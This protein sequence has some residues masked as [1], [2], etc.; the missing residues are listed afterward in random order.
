[1][2]P[3]PT[4]TAD[5]PSGSTFPVGDTLVTV[6]ATDG[7]GNT[8]THSFTVTVVLP[9]DTTSPVITSPEDITVEAISLA[10]AVVLFEISATDDVDPEPTVTADP[11]SGSVFPLGTTTVNVTAEDDSKNTSTDFFTVTVQDTA[12]PVITILAPEPYELYREDDLALDFSAY[13]LVSGDIMPPDLSGTLADAGGFYGSVEPGDKPGAGVY[14]M[15]VTAKDAADNKAEETVFFVV[16]DPTGGFVTGGGWIDSP[17]GAY[18]D[19]PSL[20]GKANFGFLSKYKKGATA[21]TGQTEFVFRAGG[22]NFHSSSYDWLVVTGSNFARFKGWGSVNGEY[23][24]RFKL[25]AGD[26]P[27]TFRIRIWV[28]DEAD[29]DEWIVYDNGPDQAI[30]GGSIVVHTG[31]K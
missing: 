2:D 5:P 3:E 22:L 15:V 4:V 16:Y 9:Q 12:L 28:E 25:W 18:K 14:S 6:T 31:R 21:P 23:G 8:S 1:V 29:A 7:S 27:D 30:E 19:N 11:L 24:Y 26:G 20:T 17:A 10:G 13:D